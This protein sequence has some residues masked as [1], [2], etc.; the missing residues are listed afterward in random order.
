VSCVRDTR[1][2][3]TLEYGTHLH[4]VTVGDER[5]EEELCHFHGQVWQRVGETKE[6]FEKRT[7][8][9]RMIL[10]RRDRGKSAAFKGALT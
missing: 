1:N 4:V 8:R 6:A 2:C 3:D 10:S 5:T 7:R 9:A